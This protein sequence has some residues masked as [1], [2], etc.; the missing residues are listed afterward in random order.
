LLAHGAEA[1]DVL[2]PVA[3]VDDI[4]DLDGAGGVYAAEDGVQEGDVL[5]D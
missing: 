4:G 2:D 5:D 1:R 3:V